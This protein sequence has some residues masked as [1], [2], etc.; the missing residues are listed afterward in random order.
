MR[1]FV[2]LLLVGLFVGLAGLG[3]QTDH[4]AMPGQP[5]D[6]QMACDTCLKSDQ[7]GM[8]DDG[9]DCRLCAL[10]ATV[11]RAEPSHPG[12]PSH[13]SKL[14]GFGSSPSGAATWLLTD[15]PPPKG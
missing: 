3:S 7:S 15:P 1:R 8:C 5:C 9:D 2:I 10:S 14:R 12:I 4:A 13:K 6:M 11:A